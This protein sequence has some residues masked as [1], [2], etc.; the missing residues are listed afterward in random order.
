MK[1]TIIN[2]GPN[3]D[4]EAERILQNSGVKVEPDGSN[5]KQV[6]ETLSD[7]GLQSLGMA[8]DETQRVAFT[9]RYPELAKALKGQSVPIE[10]QLPQLELPAQTQRLST[11]FN[12]LQKT[13]FIA[14]GIAEGT[15]TRAVVTPRHGL[16][17]ATWAMGTGTE[18]HGQW[19][20]RNQP[21]ARAG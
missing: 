10:I 7:A 19:W 8:L 6:G 17:I 3:P 20:S 21:Q 12:S 4:V 16:V 14:I 18:Q 1:T 13:L 9:E 15:R 5:L 11:S 2:Q